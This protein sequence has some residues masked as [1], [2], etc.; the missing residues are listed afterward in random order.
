MWSKKNTLIWK[1][2]PIRL[3]RLL[4]DRFEIHTLVL[5]WKWGNE[6]RKLTY[7]HQRK[8]LFGR[9]R[10]LICLASFVLPLWI[11][12]CAIKVLDRGWFVGIRMAWISCNFTKP[13]LFGKGIGRVN[14]H[15][16]SRRCRKFSWSPRIAGPV[17]VT[18]SMVPTFKTK[19]EW[20]HRNV[21][22]G[23]AE[24]CKIRETMEAS[25]AEYPGADFLKAVASL[26]K[27]WWLGTKSSQ[28]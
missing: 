24:Y 1:N 27:M 14:V 26:F 17:Q 12:G 10:T 13:I 15:C 2:C 21:S 16:W 28:W 18:L 22:D 8:A 4:T 5:G 3:L 11:K 9:N 6:K 25:N 20:T 7:R 19:D 23:T